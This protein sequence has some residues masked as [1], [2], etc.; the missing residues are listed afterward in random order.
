MFQGR[1]EDFL[2]HAVARRMEHTIHTKS[3][4][5]RKRD[6]EEDAELYGESEVSE[7]RPRSSMGTE[8]IEDNGIQFE[9]RTSDAA[10]Q[11]SKIEL[12]WLLCLVSHRGVLEL[13]RLVD[14][15]LVFRCADFA[16][17]P[18]IL[19]NHEE[20]VE[21]GRRIAN[22]IDE[23][24]LANLGDTHFEPH[25]LVRSLLP[26]FTYKQVR[27]ELNDIIIYKPY[28]YTEPGATTT[29]LR[30]SKVFNSHLTR[31]PIADGRAD[32]DVSLSP[33]R[34]FALPNVSGLSTVF[35]CG[36]YPGFILKTSQSMA[37]FYKLAGKS[38][39]SVCP[40]NVMDG[41]QDGFLYYDSTVPGFELRI[42]Q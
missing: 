21:G 39:R 6:L 16:A 36:Q 10:A 5:K 24:L 38:I 34:M 26:R 35:L 7:K 20:H 37:H 31:E 1:K 2:P 33:T 15:E 25:L 3:S 32:D 12:E 11:S 8:T 13:R 4:L 29:A 41:V 42:S 17:F 28:Q 18:D 40:L 14:L 23:I 30:F 19:C 9:T 22:T 27:T